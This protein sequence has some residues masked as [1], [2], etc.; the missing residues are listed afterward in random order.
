AAGRI[1]RYPMTWFSRNGISERHLPGDD[2]SRKTGKRKTRPKISSRRFPFPDSRFP[3]PA[4]K[5]FLLAAGLGRRFA[6][7]TGQI[8]KAIFPYLNVPI[9]AAHLR[10]L[11]QAGF[12]E[13][14]IK[15]HH[16]A[17]EVRTQLSDGAADLRQLHFFPAE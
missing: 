16:L 7:V 11:R 17:Q 9:A 10:R 1:R 2:Q 8:P 14:G 13:A 3:I 5:A 12:P 6:P 4:M 15:L